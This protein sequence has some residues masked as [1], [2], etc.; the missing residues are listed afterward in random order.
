MN[1]ISGFSLARITPQCSHI[2]SKKSLRQSD[3]F[4]ENLEYKSLVELRD[5]LGQ[6]IPNFNHVVLLSGI[7]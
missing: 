4:I 5:Y 1:N 2:P 6:F 7:R 3:A